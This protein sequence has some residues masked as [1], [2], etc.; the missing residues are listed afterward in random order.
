MTFLSHPPCSAGSI[1]DF[2]DHY[3]EQCRQ[4]DLENDVHSISA[5][6]PFMSLLVYMDSPGPVLP[7]CAQRWSKT[8]LI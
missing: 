3:E 8:P 7:T 6:A 5:D 1:H 4:N 2:L